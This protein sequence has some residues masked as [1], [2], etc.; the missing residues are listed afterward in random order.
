VIRRHLAVLAAAAALLAGACGNDS[1]S[2]STTAGPG[3]GPPARA[4]ERTGTIT[5]RNPGTGGALGTI[6]VEET[7][8]VDGGTK[9]VLTLTAATQIFR[10]G[11]GGN[12]VTATVAELAVGKKVEAWI[13]GPVAESYP[14]Q[15]TASA[16]LVLG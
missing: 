11:A 15:G 9:I 8:G 6:L 1:S 2:S 4:P 7:P 13:D 14:E 16:I 10:E 12:A 3:S 5:Q